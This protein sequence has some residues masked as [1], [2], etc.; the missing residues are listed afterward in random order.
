MIFFGFLLSPF[1]LPHSIRFEQKRTQV[2]PPASDFDVSLLRQR[3][4]HA[5]KLRQAK[6][7]LWVKG[8]EPWHDWKYRIRKT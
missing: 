1:E 7:Y 5:A 4:S 8:I 6:R 3:L 2:S